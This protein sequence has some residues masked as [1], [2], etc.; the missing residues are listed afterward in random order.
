MDYSR[1]NFN[2]IIHFLKHTHSTFLYIPFFPLRKIAPIKLNAVWMQ[3][4]MLFGYFYMVLI[5]LMDATWMQIQT[6]SAEHPNGIMSC[7]LDAY[8][9][10][11]LN[12]LACALTVFSFV[13]IRLLWFYFVAVSTLYPGYSLFGRQGMGYQ[14]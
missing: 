14:R 2:L 5:Y 7:R 11:S 6:A 1:S 3:M 10:P 13:S 9:F 8:F 12:H 4:W